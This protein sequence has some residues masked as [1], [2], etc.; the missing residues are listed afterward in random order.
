[1]THYVS[2]S[3]EERGMESGYAP[4]KH[5]NIDFVLRSFPELGN[6]NN[7]L[8]SSDYTHVK[9]KQNRSIVW[10]KIFLI[11]IILIGLFMFA[12]EVIKFIKK[13]DK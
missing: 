6:F 3:V 9:I 1:M 7:S 12:K 2:S 10:I 4:P 11:W 8:K 5:D 13:G